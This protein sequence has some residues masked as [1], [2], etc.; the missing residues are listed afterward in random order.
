M[1]A[2]VIPV[3]RIN[4]PVLLISG[5]DDCVW[6]ATELSE[7]AVRRLRAHRHPFAVDHLVYEG[8]G[9]VIGPP[10]PGLTFT[11]S[12]AVHPILGIDFAFGGEPDRNTAASLD[13][14]PRVLTFLDGAF[15]RV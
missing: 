3:E 14:W 11:I 8:A 5:T 12:H 1:A 6:P 4:G 2:A 15:A 7:I 10:M 9:H 13:S